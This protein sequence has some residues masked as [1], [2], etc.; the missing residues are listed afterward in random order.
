M[1]E[2]SMF[3]VDDDLRYAGL[4]AKQKYFLPLLCEC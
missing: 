1:L 3:E 4:A 2:M